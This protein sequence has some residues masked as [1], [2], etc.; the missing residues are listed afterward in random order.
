MSV[1]LKG[2]VSDIFASETLIRGCWQLQDLHAGL[3][4]SPLSEA[5]NHAAAAPESRGPRGLTVSDRSTMWSLCP[6]L[7]PPIPPPHIP[8]PGPVL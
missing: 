6:A 3:G 8:T 4:L 5:M 2:S 7:A 1:K